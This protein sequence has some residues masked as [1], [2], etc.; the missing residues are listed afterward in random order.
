MDRLDILD[1]KLRELERK[2]DFG[3][4]PEYVNGQVN[5][6]VIKL[7]DIIATNEV[8]TKKTFERMNSS[9]MNLSKSLLAVEKNVAAMVSDAKKLE[10]FMHMNIDSVDE[11]IDGFELVMEK[12]AIDIRDMV[13]ANK[14]MRESLMVF[15]RGLPDKIDA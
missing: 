12:H 15:L 5:A 4:Y 11:R 13:S 9:I 8:N 2:Q 14:K 3:K 1:K 6:A 10:D 7:T